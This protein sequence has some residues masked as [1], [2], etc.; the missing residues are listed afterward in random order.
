[1]GMGEVIALI[2]GCFGVIVSC[3]VL[4]TWV[5]NRKSKYMSEGATEAQQNATIA[6]IKTQYEEMLIRID[7]ISDKIDSQNDR[8]TKLEQTVKDANLADLA[9]QV[10]AISESVKSAHKRIDALEKKG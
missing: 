6:L 3:T 8:L 4:I 2:G 7:R 10:V 5:S 1:M 9:K